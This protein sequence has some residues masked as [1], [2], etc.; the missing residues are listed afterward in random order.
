MRNLLPLLL[1][2]TCPLYAACGGGNNGTGTGTGGGGSTTTSG[3]GGETG[4]VKVPDPGTVDQVDNDFTD[5]EPNNTP[6]QATPL[7]IAQGGG[8]FVW[9]NGNEIG[10]SGNPADYFVFQNGPTA[11]P[12]S[13][14][15]CFDAPVTAMTATLWKVV[16]GDQQLPALGTWTSANGCVTDPT[17]MPMLD[18]NTVYLFGLTATGG[19]GMYA[20]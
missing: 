3:M 11:G 19:P 5:M 16:G 17:A 10:G 8:V 18:A 6:S 9:V 4:S 14:D 13:F 12:L 15:I 20:A 1:A 7:G 2:I